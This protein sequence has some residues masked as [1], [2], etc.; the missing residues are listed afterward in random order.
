M[1]K[2][3]Q[4]LLLQTSNV[5]LVTIRSQEM[6]YYCDFYIVF[7]AQGAIFL[8]FTLSSITQT[9][10]KLSPYT[11][12]ANAYWLTIAFAVNSSV[13]CMVT[14]VF[15]YVYGYGLALRGPRGSVVR[16]IDGFVAERDH[17]F[18]SFIAMVITF[19]LSCLLSFWIIMTF[20][21]AVIS[22][23]LV[24][25][26]SA[27][28]ISHCSRIYSRFK[29]DNS[30]KFRTI[31]WN[32]DDEVVKNV[33][34]EPGI[35]KNESDGEDYR[36]SKKIMEANTLLNKNRG[37]RNFRSRLS[38]FFSWR[39]LSKDSSLFSKKRGEKSV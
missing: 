16:A 39:K 27:M 35:N 22:S 14:S 38:R 37:E 2:A 5:D 36:I 10:A 33:D 31:P 26:S 30:N 23:T 18:Q 9:F 11:H 20:R 7:A 12:I 19:M 1:I 28:W 15:A 13:H 24:I 6:N 4:N 34:N 17:I 21:T 3:N 8:C 32:K 25:L 29:V